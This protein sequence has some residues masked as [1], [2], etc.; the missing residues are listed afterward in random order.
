MNGSVSKLLRRVVYGDAHNKKRAMAVRRYI[1]L[2]SH[3]GTV[4]IRDNGL[5]HRYKTLKKAYKLKRSR[6][7]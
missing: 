3:R 2:K 4:T 1:G 6:G 7:Y 5:R